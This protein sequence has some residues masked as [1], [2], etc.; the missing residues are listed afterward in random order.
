[1]EPQV[2]R[3]TETAS[4]RSR[5]TREILRAAFQ[6]LVRR[7]RR[8]AV[9]ADR[10]QRRGSWADSDRRPNGGKKR[11]SGGGGWKLA[12]SRWC[13]TRRRQSGP[14]GNT[15]SDLDRRASPDPTDVGCDRVVAQDED[16]RV[17][18]RDQGLNALPPTLEGVDFVAYPATCSVYLTEN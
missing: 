11:D 13:D 15:N 2:R 8:E 6:P 1:M 7:C 10:I 9:V 17:G 14:T 3:E 5:L 16:D 12:W 4:A 18:V